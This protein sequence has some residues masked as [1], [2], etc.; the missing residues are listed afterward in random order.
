MKKLIDRDL[1][2]KITSWIK[3]KEI[4]IIIGPRQAG[5]TTFLLMLKDFLIQ[6]K[7]INPKSVFYFSFE[8]A[9]IRSQFN[10]NPKEFIDSRI[11]N[12]KGKIWIFF[13]EYHWIK[14][15]GQKL[16]FIYDFYPQI[17]LFVTGSSSLE[18]TFQTAKYLV[19]RCFYFNLFPLSFSEFLNYKNKEV[20]NSFGERHKNIWDFLSGKRKNV[21]LTPSIFEDKLSKLF[22][23]YIT[24][25]GYPEVVKKRGKN[26][27]I[28]TLKSIVATYLE[29]D[30][31]SLLLI[32]D[33]DS[34]RKFLQILSSQ[35][36]QITNYEQL[37]SDSSLY[38]KL[39]KKYLGVLEETFIVKQLR[40]FFKNFSSELR[41]NPKIYFIDTGLRNALLDDFA[42][43]FLRI[44]RGYLAENFAFSEI[45]K[46][47]KRINFWRTKSKAEVDFVLRKGL[48]PIPV[49]VKFQKMKKSILSKSFLS[50]LE[51]YQPAN[52]L[53]LTNQF[54]GKIKHGKTSVIFAPI[55]YI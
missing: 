4:F 46:K 12:I 43:V 23:E 50:F 20:F 35:A 38:F 48:S 33:I 28:M 11:K 13:D 25:G 1:F 34:Y 21:N 45:F 16:K 9:E 3:Q 24:F 29:R 39:L 30:I 47:E 40:P 15:G 8:D 14:E 54:W 7:K 19:G 6:K 10:Q 37:S 26:L 32:E 41:K 55:W 17:K 49:E 53:I 44:D 36:G 27:K 2:P 22:N 18:L 42:N 52:A 5:K 51:T 31:R